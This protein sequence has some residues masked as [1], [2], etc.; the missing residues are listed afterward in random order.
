[1]N[2]DEIL[3]AA[4]AI[5][6]A[7]SPDYN[8]HAGATLAE[9]SEQARLGQLEA[10][11]ETLLAHVAVHPADRRSLVKRVPGIVLNGYLCRNPGHGG[12]AIEQWWKQKP[13]WADSL[14]RAVSDPGRFARVAQAM[15]QELSRLKT[16]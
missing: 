8:V 2:E 12:Q 10:M 13:D 11:S 9:M 6:Q 16:T 14:R 15:A 3:R 7:G 5:A 4:T 1:M